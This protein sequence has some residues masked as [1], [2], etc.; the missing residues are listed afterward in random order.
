MG[1]SDPD[2]KGRI[3]LTDSP[4]VIR[5]K[6]KKAVTDFISEVTYDPENRPGVSNLIDIHCAFKDLFPEDI[7]EDPQVLVMDTLAYKLHLADIIVECLAPIQ[8]EMIRLEKDPGYIDQVLREGRDKAKEIASET[9]QKAR[10]QMG[11]VL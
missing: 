2:P 8:Q 9:C 3:E 5:Q 4:D 10:E 6:V 11:L 7:V 1:K